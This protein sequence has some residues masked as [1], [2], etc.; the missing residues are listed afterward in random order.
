MIS[1]VCMYAQ[2]ISGSFDQTAIGAEGTAVL[3]VIANP[4]NVN[5]DPGEFQ[6]LIDF[7]NDGS[8][9]DITPAA[10]PAA[11]VGAPAMTWVQIAD[12]GGSSSWYGTNDNVV[13][14]TIGGGEWKVTVEGVGPDSGGTPVNSVVT[15][16]YAD[17]GADGNTLDNSAGLVLDALLPVEFSNI[18]ALNQDC[19]T[20]KI[21]WQTQS[22][23]NNEGFFVERSIESTNNFES[24]GYVEGRG[25]SNSEHN[26]NYSDDINGFNNNANVYYRIK[27]VDVDGR[28]DYSDV[29][30]VKLDC[31]EAI[32]F[33]VYPNPTINELYV[34]VDGN[35]GA[36]SD[37][38]L[39]NNLNQVISTIP[40]DRNDARTKVDMSRYTAGLYYVRVLGNDNT[41]LFSDKI[42]KVGN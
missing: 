13:L 42:I 4:P 12:S 3:S 14:A 16:L 29:V 39:L 35:L 25:N 1:S 5:Q 10:G 17:S 32:S 21:V 37:V 2:S 9:I 11:E 34:Q 7:P 24:I 27:Q 30:G 15:L 20:V 6:V 28:F 26:Y 23:L 38:V 41:I 33:N 8:Y 36:A 19:E 31:I 18:N 40:V 22:E